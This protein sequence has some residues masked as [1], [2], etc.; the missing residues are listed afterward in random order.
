VEFEKLYHG[1][2]RAVF[3][4]CVRK[5]GS[6]EEA[7]DATAE[8]FIVAW[9][10]R[11]RVTATRAWLYAVARN[12]VGDVYRRRA[13]A[14]LLNDEIAHVIPPSLADSDLTDA[15]LA[16]PNCDREI[17]YWAYWERLSA[18]EIGIRSGLSAQAV[19]QRLSRART[20]LKRALRED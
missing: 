20:V 1:H 17:L 2:Y 11:H 12:V 10:H 14:L 3:L 4:T 7:E 18:S 9:R 8:V 5:L 6:Q 15:L 13:R 16:L 19:W